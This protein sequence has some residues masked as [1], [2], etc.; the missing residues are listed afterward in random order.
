ML[1]EINLHIFLGA[2]R[3][4]LVC[5]L[6]LIWMFLFSS[7]FSFSFSSSSSFLVKRM[8]WLY[9]NASFQICF[10]FFARTKLPLI[11]ASLL[12]NYF[13]ANKWP[14][15]L[16]STMSLDVLRCLHIYALHVYAYVYVMQ[17]WGVAM[18]QRFCSLRHW[19]CPKVSTN[20]DAC[21][22]QTDY[23]QTWVRL[24]KVERSTWFFALLAN[25]SPSNIVIKCFANKLQC[26][27]GWRA[28]FLF[29]GIYCWKVASRL[30]EECSQ[31][32]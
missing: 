5:T 13:I 19:P 25:Y 12:R 8:D 31:H 23:Q 17:W 21:S 4:C 24:H 9:P 30:E 14:I 29:S 11:F 2:N 26:M 18:V 28:I 7:F 1:V 6:F 27:D 20:S 22:I 16:L 32:K 3:F 15:N 10:L